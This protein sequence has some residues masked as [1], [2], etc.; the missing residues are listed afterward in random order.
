MAAAGLAALAASRRGD[1]TDALTRAVAA[2]APDAVIVVDDDGAVVEL[3][4]AAER[5]F[6]RP[7]DG[8]VGRPLDD[9]MMPGYGVWLTEGR[10]ELT[11]RRVGGEQ[12]AAEV[13][14]APVV[15]LGE[16]LHVLH[17][18]DLGDRRRTE[19]AVSGLAAIV[20]SSDDAIVSLTLDGVIESWNPGAE[21]LY[22][23]QPGEAIGR[24]VSLVEPRGRPGETPALL[25][26]VARGQHV[27]SLETLRVR[28][29]GSE[30]HV[31]LSV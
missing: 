29:D 12:F 6:G 23:H 5:M 30:V 24:P 13:T 26:L 20:Q 7:R 16:H 18:R 28:R 14:T 31:S 25:A 8:T 22:G 27:E 11:A 2:S 3:N 19:R 1:R 9:G 10:H 4:P 21:R 15:G 17:V